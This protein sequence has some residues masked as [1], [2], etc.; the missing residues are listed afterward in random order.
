MLPGLELLCL[1]WDLGQP[2]TDPFHDFRFLLTLEQPENI[3]IPGNHRIEN[4]W[5]N[6]FTL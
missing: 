1:E 5:L 2:Q 3:S 4:F 6:I